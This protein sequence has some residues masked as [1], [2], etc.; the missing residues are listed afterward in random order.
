MATDTA[1]PRTQASAAPEGRRRK[2]SSPSPGAR[3]GGTAARPSALTG[4][5]DANEQPVREGVYE[6]RSTSGRYACWS[7]TH[8]YADAATPEAAAAQ[9]RFS[10]RQALPWRGVATPPP[11][12]CFA[13]RGHSVIDHGWDDDTGRD[14]IE[15]CIEC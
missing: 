7:G 10:P 2:A 12:P 3:R 11:G 1:S 15:E 14:R 8:W 5:F 4:W 9:R 13:C 6:R